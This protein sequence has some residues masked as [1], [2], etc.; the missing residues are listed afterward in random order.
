MRLNNLSV[1]YVEMQKLGICRCRFRFE[2]NRVAFDVFF[3]ADVVP[4]ILLL[5]LRGGVFS[6][7]F[8]V[9]EEFEVKPYIDRGKYHE[10]CRL[11]GLRWSP[12]NKFDPKKFLAALDASVPKQVRALQA[13][14]SRHIAHY[15]NNLEEANLVYFWQWRDNNIRNQRVSQKNLEK[16]RLLLGQRAYQICKD[17]NISSVWTDDPSKASKIVL[18]A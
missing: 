3:L 15:W 12:D 16:T 9:S 18:P 6:V 1:L 4:Y 8:N 7:E 14:E 17:R 11:L 10:L 13:V 5:G 2:I